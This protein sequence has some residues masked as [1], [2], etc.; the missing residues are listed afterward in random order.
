[1]PTP[2]ID[3]V[4]KFTESYASVGRNFRA[5]GQVYNGIGRAVENLLD[6][7]NYAAETYIKKKS[8]ETPEQRLFK[9][10]K[11]RDAIIQQLQITNYS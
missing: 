6:S 9:I 7:M 4:G 8:E 3:I 5:H 1:M 11:E 2:K 10:E